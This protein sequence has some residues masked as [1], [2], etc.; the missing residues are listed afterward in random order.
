M[1]T[2]NSTAEGSYYKGNSPNR[3]LFKLVLR[4]RELE[5]LGGLILHVIHVAGARMIS[6]GTD[7][8][9]RGEC[10]SGVMGGQYMLDFVPLHLSGVDRSPTLLDWLQS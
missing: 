3:L 10:S 1:F 5:L 8:F 6:Q 7:G 9:S 4:L 2:D